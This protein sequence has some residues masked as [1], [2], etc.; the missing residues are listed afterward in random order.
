MY[1]ILYVLITYCYYRCKTY[2][3]HIHVYHA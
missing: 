3:F 1:I 2:W